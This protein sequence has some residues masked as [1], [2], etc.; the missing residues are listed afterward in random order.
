[1]KKILQS[2]ALLAVGA[3]ISCVTINIYF[4]AEEI[5]GAA[6]RIVDEVYGEKERPG[7]PVPVR[8]D[9]SFILPW[10]PPSAYAAQ[11]IN[12]STPEIRA[13]RADMKTRFDQFHPYLEAG[14]LGIGTDGM[15]RIR[16]VDGLDLKQRA[17][18]NRLV[19]AENQDRQR[20]YQEIAKANGFPEK[21]DEVQAIFSRSWRDKA[22]KGW[23]LEE[24][25]GDWQKK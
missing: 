21:V 4:P 20:L 7:P 24:A 14:N 8:P 16:S 17:E 1:M 25:G 5:R 13:I 2:L 10:G 9:S 11:D 3:V 19:A 18:L 12:V 23:F 15:L 6:D 22:S